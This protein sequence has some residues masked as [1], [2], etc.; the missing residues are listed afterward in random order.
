MPSHARNV[1]GREREPL[2]LARFAGTDEERDLGKQ[3]DRVRTPVLCTL[4]CFGWRL[5]L[6]ERNRCTNTDSRG[7]ES[8]NGFA[9]LGTGSRDE[10]G[11]DCSDKMK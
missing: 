2:L 5:S 3:H 4:H 9:Q 7:N 6:C 8:G 10:P 11:D 1:S